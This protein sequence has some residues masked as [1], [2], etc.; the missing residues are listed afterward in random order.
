MKLTP[1]WQ[2]SLGIKKVWLLR[3]IER[4][5]RV[6]EQE[7]EDEYDKGTPTLTKFN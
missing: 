4:E 7:S 3:G 2:G 1:G 6:Q 5:K